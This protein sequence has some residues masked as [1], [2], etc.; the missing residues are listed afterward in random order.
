MDIV[1]KSIN[2]IRPRDL[3]H[4]LFQA[5]L[6]EMNDEHGDLVYYTEVCWISRGRMLKRLFDL[7]D[8]ITFFMEQKGEPMPCW[9]MNLFSMTLPSSQM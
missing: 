7:R 1:I 5:M 9:M 4:R 2:F 3:G 8:E 6:S